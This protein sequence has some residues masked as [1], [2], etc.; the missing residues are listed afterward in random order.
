MFVMEQHILGILTD[1][2]GRHIKVVVIYNATL[3]YLQQKPWLH[4]AKNVFLDTTERFKQENPLIGII[5][6]MKKN[7]ND[8]FRPDL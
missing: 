2:R 7:F 4:W 5:F 6:A 1:Y 8:L 3:N